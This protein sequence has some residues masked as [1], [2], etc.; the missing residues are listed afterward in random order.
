[1]TSLPSNINRNWGDYIKSNVLIGS[2]ISR[3]EDLRDEGNR[4]VGSHSTHQ[5]KGGR[6]FNVDDEAGVFNCFNCGAGG[7]VIDYEMD[8]LGVDFVGACESIADMED[9]DLPMGEWSEADR[10]AYQTRRKQDTDTLTL[11]NLTAKHF[12][13]QIT[14]EHQ[15]YFE[16]RG[17][18]SKTI[19]SEKLGYAPKTN[20]LKSI[21]YR[22][23]KESDPEASD[24]EIR[25]RLLDT[26]LYLLNDDGTLRPVFR[27][28]YIFPYWRTKQ[29]IGYLIGRNASKSDTY[30]R[31]GATHQIPK[32]K[33]L[34]TKAPD[35]DDELPIARHHTLWGAHL[36]RKDGPPIVVT[37]GIV[38]ALLL[39]QEL[40]DRY[41]VI[42]P[43]TTL[44]NS[45]DIDRIIE[46]LC[47]LGKKIYHDHF[48]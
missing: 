9:L 46:R 2:Y 45:D 26:G 16:S 14:P 47:G 13:S 19:V 7:S 3:F 8:R 27:D 39:R 42:S 36:L 11:L 30:I 48:L 29:Q 15:S 31:D 4:L 33:K 43:V 38:D 40:R 22:A 41:Q 25:Q 35:G 44:I 23:V 34:N 24:E 10:E 21:L 5:S 32:Y 20:E 6:C 18:T 37:E 17:F 1:M 12:H 28:R